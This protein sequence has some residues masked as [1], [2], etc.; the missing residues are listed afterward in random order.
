MKKYKVKIQIQSN[1]ILK[2]WLFHLQTFIVDEPAIKVNLKP[3]MLVNYLCPCIPH[4]P[5]E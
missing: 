5:I 2:L 1:L 3:K 4:N